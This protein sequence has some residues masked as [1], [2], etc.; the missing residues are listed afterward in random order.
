MIEEMNQLQQPPWLVYILCCYEGE[1]HTGNGSERKQQQ[2]KNTVM[3]SRLTQM[4]QR[5]QEEK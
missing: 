2:K 3:T 4:D 5:A 1:T